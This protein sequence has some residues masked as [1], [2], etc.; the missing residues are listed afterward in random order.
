MD[1]PYIEDHDYD[2]NYNKDEILDNCF[3]LG[4]LNEVK[5][6]DVRGVKWM[7]T[8]SDTK[9]VRHVFK[10]YKILKFPVYRMFKKEYVNELIIKNY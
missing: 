6:L 10:V 4:L 9:T 8:Q 1:P 7:M 5:K 3:I 2:F